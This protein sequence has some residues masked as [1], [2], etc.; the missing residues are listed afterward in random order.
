M[1]GPIVYTVVEIR[2][3]YGCMNVILLK[4][5]KNIGKRGEVKAVSD[6]YAMNFLF[7][8]GLAEA[9]TEKAV[10]RLKSDASRRIAARIAEDEAI[11]AAAKTLAG[12]RIVIRAKA[13]SRKLFGS[14]GAVEIAAAI[15]AKGIRGVTDRHIVLSKPIKEIGEFPAAADFGSVRAK[16]QIAVEA[17]G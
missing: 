10:A 12:A 16:F 5:V 11:H 4:E 8:K 17:E 14:I 6:G 2:G 3:I 9:A 13:K 7:P 15:A 1:R